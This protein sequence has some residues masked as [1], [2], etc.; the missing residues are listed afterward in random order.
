M[1]HKIL[2]E[3]E[4]KERRSQFI[5]TGFILA[6]FG[7]QAVLWTFAISMTARD[8][9]HS[10]VAGYDEQALNWD[11]VK[12]RWE[13]SRRLGWECEIAVE[14]EGDV[15]GN[16]L[17]TINLSDSDGNPLGDVIVNLSAFHCGTASEVQDLQ[18]EQ[19]EKGI[20]S[21]G[22][23]VRRFGNWR[24]R[25][26]A[27]LNGQKFLIHRTITVEHKSNKSGDL[28]RHISKNQEI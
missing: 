27:M 21:G 25:G 15:F 17:V 19:I 10:V 24:V 1:T 23:A 16:R 8:L 11:E 6:F 13:E 2:L 20:Y 18:L 14:S 4:R 9:S 22:I 7:L 26:E 5:W 28:A 3:K 12:Q